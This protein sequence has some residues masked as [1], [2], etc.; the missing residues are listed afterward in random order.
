MEA[1]RDMTVRT[2]G[3]ELCVDPCHHGRG[4]RIGLQPTRPLLPAP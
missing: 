2:V 3:P 1:K 4:D